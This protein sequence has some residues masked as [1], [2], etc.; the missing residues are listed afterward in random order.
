MRFKHFCLGMVTS[1]L[2]QASWFSQ[3]QDIV[4]S[5]MMRFPDV[6]SSHIVFVFADDLWV[7]PRTGGL[8]YPLAAPAGEESLPRFSPDGQSIAFVGNYD[9]NQDIYV[10]PTVGGPA[11]RVT[12]HPAAELLCD[13]TP[14]GK[15]LYSSGAYSGLGR[16]T[17]LF[18]QGLDDPLETELDVPYGTNGTI[19]QDGQWLAYSPHNTDYRTWKRYRGG[20]ASEIWLFN[21]QSKQS[22]R[23]TDWEGT[24]TFPM[25]HGNNVYYLCDAGAEHRLN[26]WKFNT[27]TGE[28]RQITAFADNDCRWPSIG[29]GPNGQGEIVFQNGSKLF[30]LDLGTEA[31]TSVTITIPGDRPKLRPR[32]VDVSES[33]ANASLSPN[34][35]RVAVEARGDVWTLPTREGTPRNL[36]RSSGS[37]E[38]DPSWSPD[39]R[40]IAYFSD[41]TG[42]YELYV[43]QSDGA[44]ETKQLTTNGSAYRYSPTWSPNSKW[45]TFTDKAGG[46]HLYS[47]ETGETKQIDR[48]PTGGRLDVNWS[49]DS[50]WLT[51]AKT[52]DSRAGRSV[53]WVYNVVDGT[54]QPLT[55]G[56]F[57]DSS[58]TFDRKGEYL[59]FVSSRS[60]TSP[61]YEDLGTTFIYSDTQILM[62]LPLRRDVKN[63]LLATSDEETWKEEAKPTANE[64]KAN[65]G[66]DEKAK[67]DDNANKEDKDQKSDGAKP[68]DEPGQQPADAHQEPAKEAAQ[69]GAKQDE[70]KPASQ[71]EA[72]KTPPTFTI[73][74]EGAEARAFQLPVDAGRLSNVSVNNK[75]QV[76]YARGSSR[77]AGGPGAE[78]SGIKIFDPT[79]KDPKEKAVVDGVR[80]Y[81][82]SYDGSKLLVARGRKE[83]FVI[84]AAAGQKLEKGV[85][86]SGMDAE[87]DP[88]AEWRQVYWESWRVQRD[89]FYDPNMHGVDW[90]AIGDHYA[91]MIDECATRRDLSY[92]IK[93]MISELNVGH[94][95][96]REGDV[97]NPSTVSVGLPGCRF[98]WSDNAYKIAELYEGA[99]WDVDARNPLRAVGVN[100]G[101]YLLA[102]NGIPLSKDYGPYHA[103]QG[104]AGLLVTMTVSAKPEKDADA[105]TVSVKL[106]ASDENLRFR[107]WI[108]ANRRYVDEKTNGKVGY[109]YVVNTGIPG[110]NDLVRMLYGQ[111]DKEALIIDDRWNGGGQIPTRFIELLNRPATNAWARRDGR[112]WIWP[113]D[114]HQGPKCMLING[115]AGSGGDMFPALFKQNG[116]GPLIGM[117]TWGGLVGISGGPTNI[118]GSSVT[119]PTFAY[120]R[121]DGTWGIEGHGVDPDI[122]VI[123]D[124]ALMQNGGDPQLD[125]AIAEMLKA[126]EERPFREPKRPAYPNRKGF[127]IDPADR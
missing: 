96:Y 121:L 54:H 48:E 33:I 91:A 80:G 3:A 45:I 105:R 78:A 86:T 4:N 107:Q 8:A 39:G 44:G 115:L 89:F 93:E 60:F 109:I 16:Q 46:L 87:I 65:G 7:A 104:K 13:W 19:S 116:L 66:S 20:M 50:H 98:A 74:V 22:R 42:E 81:S 24:D 21:L 88:R 5:G 35:K 37:A 25:W 6:S 62:A 15:L 11:K 120:Y 9:G 10:I 58:P 75:G 67:S 55:S 123:D 30:L 117:R 38:R 17:K 76:I 72:P 56:F 110:Q 82:M 111:L 57:S 90:K 124:P 63:P 101:D 112:D 51:Y 47:F 2:V 97:E 31:A 12:Y 77:G 40:W 70:A 92:L 64:Q 100:V 99:V 113:P 102:V 122:E 18:V 79:E 1:L 29:P 94:A 71:P 53:V 14:D 103:F 68:A 59:Y 28:R 85:V 49:H 84:D 36:T 106:L 95:Y 118:D 34:A 27:Q 41:A 108:E 23:I 114:S 125:R 126:V 69:G 119:P 83:M 61:K 52:N 127:G 73:D 43:T 32:R 26:I